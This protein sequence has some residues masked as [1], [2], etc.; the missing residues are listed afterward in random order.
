[1]DEVYANVQHNPSMA[2]SL[3]SV[4]CLA[5][6]NR[7]PLHVARRIRSAAFQ[8]LGGFVGFFFVGSTLWA[9]VRANASPS[10]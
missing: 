6:C 10:S 3:C 5:V 1:M 8:R 7:L 9:K 2:E 4:L